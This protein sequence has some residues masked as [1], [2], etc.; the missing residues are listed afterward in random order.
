L[1]KAFQYAPPAMQK[2]GIV[3]PLIAT[4]AANVSNLSLTRMSEISEGTAVTDND[5]KVRG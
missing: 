3:I 4:A 1:G 2:Y 5:G